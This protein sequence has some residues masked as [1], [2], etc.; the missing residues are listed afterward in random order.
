M[1]KYFITGLVLLLPI[2]LT[3]AVISFLVNIL[4]KPFVGFVS[5]FLEHSSTLT[6]GFLFLTQEELILYISKLIILICIVVL[7][8]VIGVIARWFF[9]H[10]IIKLFDTLLHKVPLV[11]KIY[12]T[13]K[14]VIH[15]FFGHGK[16]TFKQ[17]V[18]VPF[19]G[20]GIYMLG[21]LSK[22]APKICQ[23]VENET[24]TSVFIPTSPNPSTGYLLMYQSKDIHK[25]DL[26]PE[27]AI[28]YI[29]SCGLVAAQDN[30][31]ESES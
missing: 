21:F 18:M 8:F 5:R 15:H 31:T 24:L 27:E 25:V 28:K 17:V 19:P 4:T 12:K 6:K 16:N 22:E 1:K 2:T 10:W 11:N 13:I 29:V 26:K 14:E 3:I 7:I 30:L 9:V 23:I 20:H